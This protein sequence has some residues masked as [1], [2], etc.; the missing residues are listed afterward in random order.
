MRQ[1][2]K[3]TTANLPVWK[4]VLFSLILLVSFPIAGIPAIEGVGYAIIHFKYGVPGKTYG[5]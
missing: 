4:K 5:L 1:P 3:T 2:A